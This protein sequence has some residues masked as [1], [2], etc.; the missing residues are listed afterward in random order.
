MAVLQPQ[1]SRNYVGLGS[2]PFARH[3]LGNNY[4]SLFLCLLRCFSSAGSL[5]DK[6]GYPTKSDG[7]PHSDIYGS[8]VVRH[9]PVAF[10]SLP[11]PSSPLRA[12]A[13]TIRP[14][15]LSNLFNLILMYYFQHVKELL[16]DS[17][18]NFFCGE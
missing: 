1:H 12:K 9:L 7:L 3:Y 8:K 16:V 17:I 4:C 13:S 18:A 5:P 15:L 10:R 6:S 11:R 2:S 14:Y